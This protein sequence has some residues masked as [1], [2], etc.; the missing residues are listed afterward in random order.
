MNFNCRAQYLLQ[1]FPP[2]YPLSEGPLSSS[3]FTL[4][5]SASVDISVSPRPRVSCSGVATEWNYLSWVLPCHFQCSWTCGG[6]AGRL[7]TNHCWFAVPWLPGGCLP[8][9]LFIGYLV[10]WE[11]PDIIHLCPFLPDCVIF[12]KFIGRSI[13]HLDRILINSIVAY[14]FSY[15]WLGFWWWFLL[16]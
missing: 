15:L 4:S 16:M 7:A 1:Y 3:Q 11:L 6:S 5:H 14:I 10:F 8:F 13:L 2:F 12:L 9:H